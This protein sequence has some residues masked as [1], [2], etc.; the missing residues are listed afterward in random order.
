MQVTHTAQVVSSTFVSKGIL[1]ITCKLLKPTVLD[2]K[3]GQYLAVFLPDDEDKQSYYSIAS[4]PNLANHIELLVKEDTLGAGANYLF[5]LKAGDEA[6]FAM[7]M[8]EA[9]LR[10]ESRH[11]IVFVAGASGASY[12]RSMIHYLDETNQLL[13]REVYYFLG[14]Q[15]EDELL[16][17]EPMVALAAKYA[18][19]H[20]IPALSGAVTWE[21]ETGL[22]TEVIDRLMT[23]DLKHWD[24]YSAGSSAMVEAV[25]DVL[26][27]KKGLQ[28]KQ[29]YSDF[30][31]PE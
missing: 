1:L 17:V 29:F 20:F 2:F 16:E 30:Y 26:I 25:A 3:A 27:D 28:A 18:N 5:S 19:F 10:E 14:A 15:E 11:N 6:R 31:S 12:V 13:D 7:P 9:F 23:N 21:G 8:G 22:I 24:V 4:S